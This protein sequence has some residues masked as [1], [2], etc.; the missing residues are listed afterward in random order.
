MGK[1]NE[2]LDGLSLRG[3]GT[4]NW[5]GCFD[6]MGNN[7]SWH[8]NKINH[9]SEKM[10]FSVVNEKNILFEIDKMDSGKILFQ[11]SVS[12][13]IDVEIDILDIM[14]MGLRFCEMWLN[15]NN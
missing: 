12:L 15:E 11:F 1:E 13:I 3:I 8:K 4:N 14:G 9:E 10:V 7:V 5:I 6:P 2:S